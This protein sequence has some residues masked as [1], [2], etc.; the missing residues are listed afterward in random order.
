MYVYNDNNHNNNN[1]KYE[2]FVS[3]DP[4]MWIIDYSCQA[5]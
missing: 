5:K 2:Y 1:N 4:H 3:T